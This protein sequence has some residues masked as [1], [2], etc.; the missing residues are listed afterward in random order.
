MQLQIFDITVLAF[1]IPLYLPLVRPLFLHRASG[2]CLM[3][4]C[5]TLQ[6]SLSQGVHFLL[7]RSG[8]NKLPWLLIIWDCLHFSLIFERQFFKYRIVWLTGVLLVG[9][10]CFLGLLALSMCMSTA[11]QPPKF[12]MSNLVLIL[13][14][15]PCMYNVQTTIICFSLAFKIPVFGFWELDY[16]GSWCL[17][18]W[19]NLKYN[20]L[21]GCLYSCVSPNTLFAPFS[22]LAFQNSHNMYVSSLEG[23]PQI[24]QALFV[25]LQSVFFLFLRLDN[26]HH[27]IF[28]FVDSLFCLLT[29]DF[30]P[31]Y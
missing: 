20:E 2:Y 10:V 24:P 31:F 12:L 26:F 23:V 14:R 3:S 18:L 28:N 25:F 8:G 4:F 9:F 11:I 7:G 22:L 5:F 27:P 17:S 13:L 6:A 30:E 16:N 19:V 21:L 29:S 15:I 1:K